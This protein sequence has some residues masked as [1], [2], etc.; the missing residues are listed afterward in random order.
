MG[1]GRYGAGRG[2]G[3]PPREPRRKSVIRVEVLVLEGVSPASLSL[4]L[5]LLETANWLQRQAGRSEPFAIALNGPGAD[6]AGPPPDLLVAPGLRASGDVGEVD[7]WLEGISAST[8]RRLTTAARAGGQVASCGAGVFLLASA[9][10][11]DGR[12]ATTSW[13]LASDFSR[14]FPA[15]DLRPQSNVM[16][17]G[18]VATAAAPLAQ[19]DLMLALV[20]RHAGA[21]LAQRCA[22]RLLAVE[23]PSHAAYM[24]SDFLAAADERV[25]SAER[26]ALDRLGESFNVDELAGAAGLSARTFAR[27]LHRSTGLSPVRFVQRLRV[28]QAVDLLRTTR[29]P[30]DEIARRVGYAEPSTLRRLLRREGAAGAREIRGQL[31]ARGA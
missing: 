10:L 4:T 21:D 29:L 30:F 25:A 13:W 19:L 22:S 6:E 5:E 1:D 23:Q 9:G 26:W 3:A 18:P 12:R 11:L 24:A 15:V 8:R 7:R 28:R 2:D 16:I 14:R 17:D 31:A 27:R 20:A